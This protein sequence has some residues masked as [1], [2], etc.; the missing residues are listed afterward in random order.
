MVSV[1]SYHTPYCQVLQVDIYS[2]MTTGS[3]SKVINNFI[4][5][6]VFIIIAFLG[7]LGTQAERI[8]FIFVIM[9]NKG[10]RAEVI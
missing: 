2:Q 7:K 6:S 1:C 3:F 4:I 10:L 5:I 8:I 9:I